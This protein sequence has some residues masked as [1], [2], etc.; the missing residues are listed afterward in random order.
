MHSLEQLEVFLINIS[1]CLTETY[2]QKWP[3]FS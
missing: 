1:D 2:P 3:M